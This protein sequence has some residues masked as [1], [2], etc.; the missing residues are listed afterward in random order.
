[1]ANAE[2]ADSQ[3]RRIVSRDSVRKRESE[4]RDGREITANR[5]GGAETQD[6]EQYNALSTNTRDGGK[7]GR[8]RPLTAPC[9]K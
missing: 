8:T 2:S 9:K 1:M 6:M 5:E 3:R 7:E 4:V